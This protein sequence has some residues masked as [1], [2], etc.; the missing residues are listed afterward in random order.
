M[1]ELLKRENDIVTLKFELTESV[2]VSGMRR[3][4]QVRCALQYLAD[5]QLQTRQVWVGGIDCLV[6]G[7]PTQRNAE[8][9]DDYLFALPPELVGCVVNELQASGRTGQPVWVHLVK[10]YGAL[11]FV[12]WERLLGKAL[13]VPILMLPDFIFPP[14][15]GLSSA[16][17][18]AICG[19][20]PL[21]CEDP[22]VR[23]AV[24]DAIMA[25]PHGLQRLLRLHVFT[26]TDVAA[27]LQDLRAITMPEYVE[28]IFHDQNEAAPYVVED[29][30]SR[31][32][33]QGN[34]LRS[35]WL[36][37]M[38]ES[39]KRYS[40]DVVHFICHGRL[41]RGRGSMLFAQSPLERTDNYLAGPV[42][43]VELQAF[44][45]QIGAWST[46]FTSPQDN[47]SE[48]GLRSLADEIAQSRPGPMMLCAPAHG[49]GN[50]LA[51]GY[52]FL[53][54]QQPQS[55]PQ[56][57]ALFIYCQPYLLSE[58]RGAEPAYSVA[59]HASSRIERFA[60]N[61]LQQKSVIRSL[62]PQSD[63]Q[64][65][66]ETESIPAVVS[67][68]ERLAEQ[69]QVQYQQVVRDEVIPGEIAE[70]E[71]DAAMD[72]LDLLRQAVAEI[73]Q[74]RLQVDASMASGDTAP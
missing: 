45:T 53:Y 50:E 22:F 30:S 12:P 60:R 67:A 2:L 39:L 16:L 43:A 51:A 3:T 46:V 34:T 35:P 41:S 36:L 13:A 7:D 10:P 47:H 19:S 18:V 14:P 1:A 42:G 68:T 55:P 38:R 8:R 66:A 44:L 29:I 49:D 54:S 64:H 62:Q 20:A 24:R 40:I 4:T 72:T 23:D 74:R 73:E 69:M 9:D 26:D 31:L 71:M 56:S 5:G 48:F 58:S 63:G 32:V 21:D 37:W 52:R 65:Y 33:D 57:L 17:D 70:L 28:L 11:R 25:I 6:L 15:R 61:A 59:E 27:Q